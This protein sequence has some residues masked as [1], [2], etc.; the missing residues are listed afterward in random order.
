[1]WYFKFMNKSPLRCC[2]LNRL[3]RSLWQCSS[4]HALLGLVISLFAAPA[5]GLEPSCKD[6]IPAPSVVREFLDT[7]W[8]QAHEPF[9][10]RYDALLNA[11]SYLDSLAN[12]Q[13]PEAQLTLA[14][15][16]VSPIYERPCP[17]D[18]SCTKVEP[19]ATDQRRALSI[20]QALSQSHPG[21]VAHWLWG[22]RLCGHL[23][24][25]NDLAIHDC[26]MPFAEGLR[27]SH[28]AD[29]AGYLALAEIHLTA[30][31]H[32]QAQRV[33]AEAI[34]ARQMTTSFGLTVNRQAQVLAKH[35]P[36]PVFGEP[37]GMREMALTTVALG[38]TLAIDRRSFRTTQ[39]CS[40]ST[41]FEIQQA[42]LTAA[43]AMVL[44]GADLIEVKLSLAIQREILK[45][46]VSD[47]RFDE[48]R[49][50]YRLRRDED[51]RLN[52]SK[53]SQFNADDFVGY[54]VEL[55]EKGE[56]AMLKEF[57][58]LPP[59]CAKVRPEDRVAGR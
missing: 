54:F 6:P 48:R 15:S 47:A 53:L 42:C 19:S 50:I 16:L 22:I 23:Y 59:H 29:A 28:P 44:P 3:P 32:P 58:L 5:L 57:E 56:Y 9:M 30:N 46:R 51:A 21:D 37:E 43:D 27:R 39:F 45:R 49:T 4:K 38:R 24:T 52:I 33:M 35:L 25:D 41:D 11:E 55:E 1:M 13:S 14:I 36:G 26:V 2:L 17:E 7:L 40:K 31:E 12:D 18:Q 20:V 8:F 10:E 34:N